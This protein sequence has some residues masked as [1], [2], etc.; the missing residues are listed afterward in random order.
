MISCRFWSR[1]RHCSHRFCR[2]CH[3]SRRWRSGLGKEVDTTPGVPLVSVFAPCSPPRGMTMDKSELV[4]KAK[5]AEQV[6]CYDDMAAAVKA[7]MEQGHE[8]SNEERKLLSVVYK[9]MVRGL[10]W[11]RSG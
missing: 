4:Q 2:R 9:N 5:L 3:C 8:L 7:V 11:W 1:G 10:P 6:E